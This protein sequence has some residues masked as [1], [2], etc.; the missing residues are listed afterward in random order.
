MKQN[1]QVV[2]LTESQFN[3]VVGDAVKTVLREEYGLNEA[4][5]NEFWG[6]MKNMLGGIG[7]AASYAW[8]KGKAMYNVGEL[9]TQLQ[10]LAQQKAQYE[11]YLNKINQKIE[12]LQ[13]NIRQA[14]QSA[15]NNKQSL[16]KRMG[17][18]Q[19]NSSTM[20]VQQQDKA[21]A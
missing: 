13:A 16:Q 4:Q 14:N 7:D 21:T 8:N 19:G 6:G 10:K 11:Q 3:A 1:R 12:Q 9:N 17:M 5:I 2:R 18:Q 20:Q 15:A